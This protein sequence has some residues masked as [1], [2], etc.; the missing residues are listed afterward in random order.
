MIL[1]IEFEF[2]SIPIARP[3]AGESIIATPSVVSRLPT[4]RTS[5]VSPLM[6]ETLILSPGM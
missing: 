6:F 3:A 2:G 5:T 4:T 1:T